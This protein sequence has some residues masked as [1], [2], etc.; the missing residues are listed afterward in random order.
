MTPGS[1][2]GECYDGVMRDMIGDHMAL[3][4]EGRAGPEVAVKNDEVC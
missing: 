2:Q 4:K 3:V 1:F